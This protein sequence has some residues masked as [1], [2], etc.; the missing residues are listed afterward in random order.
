MSLSTMRI[1]GAMQGQVDLQGLFAKICDFVKLEGSH[2]EMP[3]GQAHQRKIKFSPKNTKKNREREREV[4][5]SEPRLF[6]CTQYGNC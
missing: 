5:V 6:Q 1:L 4:N 2:T 3:R